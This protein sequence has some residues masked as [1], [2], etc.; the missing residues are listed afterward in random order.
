MAVLTD[1]IHE[2]HGVF[3]TPEGTVFFLSP[4]RVW[5]AVL[6]PYLTL[7]ALTQSLAGGNEFPDVRYSPIHFDSLLARVYVFDD[8]GTPRLCVMPNLN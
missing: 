2:V 1:G 8:E 5:D 4:E 7:F 3:S 6:T